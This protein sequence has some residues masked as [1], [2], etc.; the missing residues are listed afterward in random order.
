[1]FY[2]GDGHAMQGDGEVD[3]TAIEISLTPTMQLIVHPGAGKAL[4]WPRAEDAAHYYVMGMDTN[5]DTALK[6]A[7]AE[8]VGFLQQRAGLSAA[9]AYALASLSVDFRVGE[10]VNHVKMV[11]GVI[12]KKLFRQNPKYWHAK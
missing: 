7:V 4:K 1:L 11:Y 8:T 6:N 12:P 2:T 9:D 10:A 5:L 3:G